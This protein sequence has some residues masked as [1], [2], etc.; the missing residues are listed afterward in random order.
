MRD[1]G[2]EGGGRVGRSAPQAKAW[3]LQNYFLG[4][5]ACGS[6]TR[7]DYQSSID[8]GYWTRCCLNVHIKFQCLT[9]RDRH[10]HNFFYFVVKCSR[11]FFCN[12][13]LGDLDLTLS[14]Y[15]AVFACVQKLHK[16]LR[17]LHSIIYSLF[18]R[19][20]I[21]S[22]LVAPNVLAVDVDFYTLFTCSS[23]SLPSM[24]WHCWLGHLAVE[25]RPRYDQYVWSL[26]WD[27][28]PCSIYRQVI[29]IHVY[30]ICC[31]SPV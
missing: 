4:A 31:S 1:V 9:A 10:C 21:V 18:S 16:T 3:P 5:G 24:L 29:C 30:D 7:N 14:R 20:N 23:S 19:N 8:A 28:K 22:L 26:C 15:F 12:L 27:V 6:K 13:Q 2:G 25:S 11:S 17:I